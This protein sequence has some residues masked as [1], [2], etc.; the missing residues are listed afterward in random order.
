MYEFAL[1]MDSSVRRKLEVV[2]N[3]LYEKQGVMYRLV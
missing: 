2:A 1:L 3:T